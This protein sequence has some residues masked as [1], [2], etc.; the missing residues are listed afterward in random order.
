M[1]SKLAKL[2]KPLKCLEE[3]ELSLTVQSVSAE[4]DSDFSPGPDDDD[5]DWE[6]QDDPDGEFDTLLAERDAGERIA[7][8]LPKLKKFR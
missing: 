8:A 1:Q 6:P 4:S 7:K 2:L 3:L 5:F